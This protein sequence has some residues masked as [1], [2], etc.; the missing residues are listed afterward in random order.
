MIDHS[1]ESLA[2]AGRPSDEDMGSPDGQ[3]PGRAVL[4]PAD[5]NRGEV[6]HQPSRTGT[7]RDGAGGVRAGL[8]VAVVVE[9]GRED[10]PGQPV[11][12]VEGDPDE[13][14]RL[15]PHLAAPGPEDVP[16]RFGLFRPLLRGLPG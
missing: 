8:V 11:V 6:R 3:R 15:P 2:R 12:V 4:A 9:V 10:R 16:E 5:R 13:P 14:E 7:G 1:T